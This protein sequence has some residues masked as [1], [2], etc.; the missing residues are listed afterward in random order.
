MWICLNDAY[1]SIVAHRDKPDHLLVRGRRNG[2]IEKLFPTARVQVTPEADYRYRTVLPR[3]GVARVIGEY[4]VEGLDY[5]N[6]KASVR[7]DS[8]HDAYLRV[9]LTLAALQS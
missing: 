4:L 6:F 5:S 2:D 9:W 1:L 3:Q 7:D 8:L